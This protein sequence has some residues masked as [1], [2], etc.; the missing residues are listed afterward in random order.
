MADKYLSMSAINGMRITLSCENVIGAFVINGLNYHNTSAGDTANTIASVNIY[1]P[2]FYMNMVRVDPTVDAQLIKSAQNP[3]DGNIRIH[4]QTYSMYQMSILAGQSTFEYIIPVKVSSLKA[5]YF[6]LAPQTY[7]G[8]EKFKLTQGYSS[9]A[10]RVMTGD[11]A[12]AATA[13]TDNRVIKLL[14]FRTI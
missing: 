14:G 3:D 4:S 10:G 2:T 7:V 11:G 5:I 9:L 6:T 8:Y 1:D 12:A 13:F